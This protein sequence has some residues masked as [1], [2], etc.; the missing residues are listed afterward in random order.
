MG[1]KEAVWA[2]FAFLM[3]G[4]LSD[5]HYEKEI[6]LMKASWLTGFSCSP[7]LSASAL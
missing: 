3:K 7:V 5:D 1:H 2:F 4:F 6:T